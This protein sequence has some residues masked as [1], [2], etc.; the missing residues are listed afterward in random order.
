MDQN[1][2]LG[3]LSLASDDVA[4]AIKCYTE[5]LESALSAVSPERCLVLV[6]RCVAYG[7]S[8][9]HAKAIQDYLGISKM[10]R[11]GEVELA[12]SVKEV[13]VDKATLIAASCYFEMGE[14]ESC[15][16]SL[17]EAGPSLMAT[18]NAKMLKRKCQAE[19][20]DAEP[21]V[22]AVEKEASEHRP[23]PEPE[24]K[25][26]PPQPICK[27][28]VALV[29]PKYI[30]S[31]TK[32]FI[33]VEIFEENVK[34]TAV[35]CV[36]PNPEHIFFSITRDNG[37][38]VTVLNGILFDEVIVPE[39]KF[40]CKDKKVIVKLRKSGQ[41]EWSELYNKS[42]KRR[43][44]PD[45]EEKEYERGPDG[46]RIIPPDEEEDPEE[47]NN[48]PVPKVEGGKARAYAS[49]RDWDA[50]DKNLKEA[51]EKEKPKGEDALNKLFSQIYGNADDET[52]RA[53]IKSFQT[54]GGT[55]LSTN[56]DEVSKKDYE[57]ERQAP[58][59]MQWK[60]WEGDK[61]AQKED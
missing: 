7:R 42:G 14:F 39:C 20:E 61:L 34:E 43:T 21:Q 15:L 2:V 58:K 3:D 32:K 28:T 24:P 18:K 51:E 59:G 19:L 44:K 4:G 50:I 45:E 17:E 57:K 36:Y 13:V 22:E 52:R 35:K 29:V 38:V 25:P 40:I 41:N 30:Y 27:N 54:S 5:S 12:A 26:E 47:A 55:V 60:N 6:K 8:G 49:H 56:W 1:V 48:V 46:R 16:S 33:K 31:Q 53:M 37:D 23:E 9:M 10:L 11:S